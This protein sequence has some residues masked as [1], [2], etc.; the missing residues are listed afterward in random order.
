MTIP[1]KENGT[2]YQTKRGF[3]TME[4]IYKCSN[5]GTHNLKYGKTCRECKKV[6]S[7][8][9]REIYIQTRYYRWFNNQ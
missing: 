8:D 9:E 6:K 4:Y 3:R 2:F 1:E 5:H 7:Y